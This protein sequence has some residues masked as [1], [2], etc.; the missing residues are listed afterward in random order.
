MSLSVP[1]VEP[2][3]TS[4]VSPAVPSRQPARRPAERR[5]AETSQGCARNFLGQRFVYLLI[6]PRAQGLSVGVNL[7]PDKVCN[8]DC[9]YCEVDRSVAP[10]VRRLDVDAMARELEAT[11]RRVAAGDLRQLPEFASVPAALL[12][13]K[14]VT[15][16]GDGEPTQCP[17]FAAA[18]EA[19]TY[20]RVSARVPFFRLVLITNASGLDLPVVQEG[21]RLFTPFDEIWAKLDVGTQAGMDWINRT[22]VPLE[23]ILANILET[24]RR[25]PVTIQSLFTAVDGRRLPEAEI[26]AYAERLKDLKDAGANIPLVQI[27]SANRPSPRGNCRHLDLR[28]LSEIARRV[29]AVS[30]LNAEVY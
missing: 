28:E 4:G 25:R 3:A 15:L 27:Y 18:V 6:S 10:L 2:H 22:A 23:K 14:H 17:E 26:M 1:D 20:L 29:R 9:V 7:N 16:S 12:N 24:A 8:F 11:L 5:A 21:L 30:G 13:L 19:I